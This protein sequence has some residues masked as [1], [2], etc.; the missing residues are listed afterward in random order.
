MAVGSTLLPLNRNSGCHTLMLVKLGMMLLELSHRGAAGAQDIVVG[1]SS[2]AIGDSTR[3]RQKKVS[4]FFYLLVS[5]LEVRRECNRR[6]WK[7][8]QGSG[9]ADNSPVSLRLVHAVSQVSR[10]S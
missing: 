6:K 2:P 3:S 9:T 8:E 10:W 4:S 5:L 1:P 7:N